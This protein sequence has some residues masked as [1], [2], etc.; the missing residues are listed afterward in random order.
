M[1]LPVQSLA[2]L[3]YMLTGQTMR[4]QLV[5]THLIRMEGGEEKNCAALI[6][7]QIISKMR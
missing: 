5:N 1:L 3:G 7:I 2:A 4:L 6:R